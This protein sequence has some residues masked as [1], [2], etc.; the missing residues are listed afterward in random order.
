MNRGINMPMMASRGCPYQCTFCSNPTMWTTRWVVR[1][2]QDVI[3]EIKHYRAIY[4]ATNFDFHDLTAIVKKSWIVEFCTLLIRGEARHHL[5]VADRHALGGHRRR[6]GAAA[7][8]VGLPEHHL[9]A[10]KRHRRDSGEGEEAHQARRGDQVDARLRQGRL[11]CEGEPAVRL[12]RRYLSPVLADA[13]IR[14]D[15]GAHRRP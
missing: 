4:K 1:S 13:E 6:G 14:L 5:A 12:P 15:D 3:A 10:R 11:Q 8:G 2:P 7:V 9:R